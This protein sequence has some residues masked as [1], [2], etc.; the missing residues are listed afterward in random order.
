MMLAFSV[1]SPA[2]LWF[3]TLG[4]VPLIIYLINRQRYQRIPWAAMEFLLRAMKKHRKRI[5]LENL[6]LLLIRT[7][8]VLIFVFAMAR[9]ALESEA[10][11][12]LGSKNR[13]A[14][15]I[16]DRSHSMALKEGSR[17]LLF[18]ARERTGFRAKTLDKGD[19][20]GLFLAGGFPEAALPQPLVITDR[21]PQA[22]L[23]ELDQ[24]D[25]RYERLDV[26]PTLQL[27][28]QWIEEGE[29]VGGTAPWEMHLYTD[30][31]R[32]D[33]LGEG[34]SADPSILDAIARLRDQRTRLVVHPLGPPRP[35]NASVTSLRCRDPLVT[36]DL[37]TSFQATVENTC[38][39]ALPELE[40]EL[41][42]NGEVQ[43]SRR[44][45]LDAGE[46]AEVSF[47]YIFRETG[48]ARVKAV[49]MSDDLTADNELRIVVDVREAV[50][51]LIA[52]G[53]FDPID[54]SSESDWLQ[55]ALLGERAGISGTRLTPY[56]MQVIAAERLQEIPLEEVGVLILANVAQLSPGE[57]DAIAQFL[58]NGGGALV[59]AG[60]RV[61][62]A[63]YAQNAY[64]GGAGWFPYAPGSA[65][66][67]EK[68]ET[69]YHWEVIDG[70]HPAVRFLAS[71]PEAGLKD[72]AVHGFL[73]PS[74]P[75]PEAS[76]LIALGDFDRTPA[77]VEK[78]VG[79]GVCL[80]LNIG[81]DRAWSNFPISPA[82]VCF[83]YEA[84]PY[85]ATRTAVA[86][87][88]AVGEPFQRVV[89]ADEFSSR[90]LLVRPDG[91]GVPLSLEERPDRRSFDLRVGPQERPGAY[92][93]RFAGMTP[94]APSHSDW[95]VVNADPIEGDLKRV[96]PAELLE[97]Y[98]GLTLAR[99]RREGE[100]GAALGGGDGD[101]WRP[102]FWSVLLLLAFPPLEAAAILQLMDRVAH[103]SFYMP[104]NLVILGD[105][106]E[107]S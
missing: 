55:A 63:S 76:V 91:D 95:F 75:V 11:P 39:D 28:A 60:N 25:I 86:R 36:L 88:L 23:E 85:L 74:T 33:W 104:S 98:P 90:V 20:A 29:S 64:R 57:S 59:F 18:E 31:Q 93:V 103:T 97:L 50:E 35:R 32:R 6:L 102:L 101:L 79:E 96:V 92:E 49:L 4:L 47:P 66:I 56:R 68:R 46:S 105:V 61:N 22:I 82:F 53:G 9:P 69:F 45:A 58:K 99:D 48:P 73:K 21:G 16:I 19:R 44:I 37:M 38:Q 30:L 1:A 41:W 17:T 43:A 72:V 94:D 100:T 15:F 10:L 3:L 107:G 14:G 84:L 7:V 87:T 8:L 24:L 34:G 13:S 52:D 71:T 83:L 40:L 5:R 89:P 2:M 42:V 106:Y 26:A 70:E 77:L 54:G 78:V 81:A 67:D 12:L 27:V 51:L 80:T 62:P 65:V